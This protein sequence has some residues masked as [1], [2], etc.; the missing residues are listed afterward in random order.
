MCTSCAGPSP[1]TRSASRW[2]TPAFTSMARTSSEHADMP[3]FSKRDQARLALAGSRPARQAAEAGLDA[4]RRSELAPALLSAAGG[5]LLH[6][7]RDDQ[8]LP[9]MSVREA[10]RWLSN[11][12]C[13]SAGR[14]AIP[15]TATALADEVLFW[16][17]I[18]IT[19]KIGTV[20]RGRGA[21]GA[22]GAVAEILSRRAGDPCRSAQETSE[23]LSR[24][25]SEPVCKSTIGAMPGSRTVAAD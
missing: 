25:R 9:E 20:P 5:A 14:Q 3:G 8:P 2:R 11:S 19:L 17:R 21:C 18:G 6:R 23:L 4:G 1:C 13:R 10:A 15:I 24:E 12:T 7:A 16:R 22:V